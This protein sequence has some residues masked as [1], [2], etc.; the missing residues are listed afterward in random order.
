MI[1]IAKKIV[2]IV[3]MPTIQLSRMSD[4][5]SVSILFTLKLSFYLPMKFDRHADGKLDNIRGFMTSLTVLTST[6]SLLFSC[7]KC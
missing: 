3:C 4:E 7:I 6:M 1:E 2:T 5:E